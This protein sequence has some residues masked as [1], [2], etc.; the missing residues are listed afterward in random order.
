MYVLYCTYTRAVAFRGT[1]WSNNGSP[2]LVVNSFAKFRGSSQGPPPPPHRFLASCSRP[3]AKHALYLV[4]RGSRSAR[5]SSTSS[6]FFL[7]LFEAHAPVALGCLCFP[8]DAPFYRLVQST[9]KLA[10]VLFVPFFEALSFDL[11]LVFCSASR[12]LP[13]TPGAS[14]LT[15]TN[16]ST[17]DERPTYGKPRNSHLGLLSTS[18]P[19][20]SI[21]ETSELSLGR[22][23]VSK[24]QESPF[25]ALSRTL[26]SQ[27]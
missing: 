18:L 25:H 10:Q 6:A 27:S 12:P 5:P 13:G 23:S 1:G 4:C 15:K 11:S 26:S 19:F 3:A 22:F 9:L 20:F 21:A 8:E 14:K 2:D 7:L 24:R 17:S 16:P